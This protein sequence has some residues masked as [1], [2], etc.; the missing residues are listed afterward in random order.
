MKPFRVLSDLRR[1]L[2]V[3]RRLVGALLAALAT[4]L[5]VQAATAPPPGTVPVW[6]A[7]A[8]LPSGTVLTRDDLARTGFARDSVPASAVRSPAAVLGRTLAIPL[9]RGDPITPAHLTGSDALA[10]FP[11]RSAVA[12][13]IP[14]ADVAAL[15]TPGQQVALVAT[16]PQGGRPPERLVEDATV[17][18]VPRASGGTSAGSLSG[19]LVVFAVPA[20]RSDEIAAA[21]TSRYLAVVWNR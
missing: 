20:E 8:D 14:D 6:T 1:H 19:R 3:H 21:A 4:W 11:G 16:D 9:G 18:A 12:V 5:V 10:G 2:L 15:L 13:R 7:A 17:L